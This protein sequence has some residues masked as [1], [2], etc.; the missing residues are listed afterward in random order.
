MTLGA[1]KSFP[2]FMNL[3]SNSSQAVVIIG[4]GFAGL[5]AAATLAQAGMRVTVLEKHDIPGGRARQF[6]AEGFTFDMGPSWYWMPDVMEDFFAGFGRRCADYFSLDRLDPSY[7]I[8]FGPD[9][10]VDLPARVPD[11]MALFESIEPGAGAALAR[12]LDEA[13]IKYEVGIG[14]FAGKP[15]LS[16]MEFA[17]PRLLK[18]LSSMHLL[19]SY[20]SHVSRFFKHP[21]LH[22]LL[23][24]PILFLGG[25]GKSTP[26]LYSMMNYGD[27]VLGTWYPKGGMF[28][29][30]K[31]MHQ[32]AEE[33]GAEFMFNTEVTSIHTQGRQVTGVEAD[34]Q[35]FPADFVLGAGDYHHIE[36]ELLPAQSR[37]YSARY[38]QNRVMSPSA[39]IFYLGIDRPLPGLLHHTLLF[40]ADFEAHAAQI[41]EQ[42][43][44]PTHPALYLNVTSKTDPST[45]PE[46]MEN[47][48]VL[49]P[50]ATGLED[51]EATRSHYQRLALERISR[52]VGFDVAPH[53]IYAR[54]YAHK[55][56]IVDYHAFGGNAYGLANI[57]K[58]TA[59]LKP[60]LKSRRLD[61]LYYA[62]Q[63]TVPGPGVPPTILSG[64][65]AAREIIKQ[66]NR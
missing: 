19:R 9:D 24:F 59:L 25:T 2:H 51:T 46:G 53:V 20:R 5:A 18:Y 34:G 30:V 14:E 42:P 10:V 57:L 4:A 22:R 11:A 6:S 17:D 27:L 39:L 58:Q 26:A 15:C 48:M 35:H 50:V 49:I 65:S 29:L 7:R 66:A 36:Q 52:M 21:R 56:F 60:R 55:D 38:W 63:L 1:F 31:A 32:L 28:E 16:F 23:E 40:D 54:S 45:A 41:Y 62:G 13:K 3:R 37:Q 47:L 43:G 44:W 33:M 64:R 12:F 61:N 8:L